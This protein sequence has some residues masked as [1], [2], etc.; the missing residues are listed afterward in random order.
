MTTVVNE[1]IPLYLG[2][3]VTSYPKEDASRLVQKYGTKVALEIEKE[4]QSLLTEL[5]QLQPDWNKHTLVSGSKWAVAELRRIHPELDDHAA[6][7]LEWVY[8]WW[9][10]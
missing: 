10:K 1:G 9:W 7:A 8:S 4:V 2:Y 6:D 3:G 5:E